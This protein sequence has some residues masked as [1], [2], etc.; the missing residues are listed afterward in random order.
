MKKLQM[1]VDRIRESSSLLGQES[2]DKILEVRYGG[3]E[4]VVNHI[5]NME[6]D[7]DKKMTEDRMELESVEIQDTIEEIPTDGLLPLQIME[8]IEGDS[9][10]G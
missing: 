7:I 6:Q 9:T 4:L 2:K 1:E 3:K 5:E 8:N 10:I